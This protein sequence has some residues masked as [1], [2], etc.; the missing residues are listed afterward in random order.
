MCPRAHISVQGLLPP[1]PHHHHT[2]RERERGREGEG[3]W[4]TTPTK[5]EAPTRQQAHACS[6]GGGASGPPPPPV[7]LRS[8][9]CSLRFV[10]TRS[11]SH[12]YREGGGGKCVSCRLGRSCDGIH[13]V[14]WPVS[15]SLLH[16]PPLLCV[17]VCVWPTSS[18]SPVLSPCGLGQRLPFN[19]AH[20]FLKEKRQERAAVHVTE[21]EGDAQ[22]RRHHTGD[23]AHVPGNVGDGVAPRKEADALQKEV[24]RHEEE[25]NH[26]CEGGAEGGGEQRAGKDKPQKKEDAHV[27]VIALPHAVALRPHDEDRRRPP[28]GA[29]RRRNSAAERIHVDQ[30]KEAAQKLGQTAK[31]KDETHRGRVQRADVRLVHAVQQRRNAKREEAERRRRADARVLGGDRLMRWHA[32]VAAAQVF[33]RVRISAVTEHLQ[34]LAFSVA[35]I[36]LNRLFDPFVILSIPVE[37]VY[38]HLSRAAAAVLYH[39]RA[40][41][42]GRCTGSHGGARVHCRLARVGHTSLFEDADLS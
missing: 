29:V 1:S 12:T 2:H 34:L 17:C 42:N 10:P 11:C 15:S 26:A 13:G 7:L 35:E 39:L 24:Q 28:E 31:E 27:G 38:D 3:L 16:E 41:A 40:L 4:R 8:P 22:V 37:I 14:H 25:E 9:A 33:R 18:C 5:R 30:L 23:H 36:V 19:I 32:R 21:G 20:I 6:G